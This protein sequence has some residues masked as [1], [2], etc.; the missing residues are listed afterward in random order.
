MTRGPGMH[1]ISLEVRYPQNCLHGPCNPLQTD[2]EAHHQL[3]RL[4]RHV[5]KR[6]I[7]Q[8]AP[9]G[10]WHTI[11][12]PILVLSGARLQTRVSRQSSSQSDVASSQCRTLAQ[13]K[14]P[15]SL[16]QTSQSDKE[17]LNKTLGTSQNASSTYPLFGFRPAV[18]WYAGWGFYGG[19]AG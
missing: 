5:V 14:L 8:M 9:L 13:A 17:V 3:L 1:H 10:S 19:M 2:E 4:C 16:E 18:R 12:L 6:W 15:R 11:S 7:L